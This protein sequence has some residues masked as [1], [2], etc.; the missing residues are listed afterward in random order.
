MAMIA[1][2]NKHR[3]GLLAI[4]LITIF[5]L[6]YREHAGPSAHRP[7]N[8]SSHRSTVPRRKILKASMLYGEAN[9][10]LEQAL[11]THTRHN[12][13][14]GYSMHI[15]REE[16]TPG[17]WNK[18][19]YLQ[20]LLVTELAKPAADRA[21][22]ILYTAPD[23]ILLNPLLPLET[24]LPPTSLAP[25][26][27]FLGV[28]P[29]RD[30]PGTA[31]FFLQVHRD[32]LSL[33]VETMAMPLLQATPNQSPD[34][35]AMALGTVLN[36]TNFRNRVYYTPLHWFA[37]EGPS[38]GSR[39]GDLLIRFPPSLGGDRWRLMRDWIEKVAQ[40]VHEIPVEGLKLGKEAEKFWGRVRK[41][42]KTLSKG[43][44][45]VKDREGRGAQAKDELYNSVAFL[46]QAIAFD[47]EDE[48]ALKDGMEFVEAAVELD[49]KAEKE[50]EQVAEREDV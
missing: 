49:V 31:S 40:G 30:L 36:E 46:E 48:R 32:T 19:A 16:I 5:Y 47:A 43:E 3:G 7:I 20:S 35:G 11:A 34:V 6:A 26:P 9:P 50:E 27:L 44:E 42:R 2:N 10:L 18:L 28:R 33:L 4:V 15:L 39:S 13:L 1:F 8:T 41:A 37:G 23:T 17:Y 38:R 21:Q 29:T 45:R 24:F 14:N 12:E 25:K 22:W